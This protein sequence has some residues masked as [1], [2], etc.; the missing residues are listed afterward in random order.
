MSDL[1]KSDIQRQ[2]ILNNKYALQRITEYIGFQGLLFENE[3]RFTK[4]MISEFYEIDER[5]IE[6]YIDKHETE[7]K[8]NGYVLIRGK[9]LKEFKLQFATDIY[10]G[11]KTTVLGLFNFRA[12]LNLG[13]LLTE[14]TK[15]KHL[16]SKILD[17]VID[18]INEK[19]GGGTKFINRQDADYLPAAIRES[20]YR[21]EF[22]SALSRCVDLGNY[23]YV[24]YTDR[25]YQYIFKENAKE[26]KQILNLADKDNAR[27]TMYAEILNLIASFETGLAYEL[28]KKFDNTGRKL[29]P[30]EVEL[31]FREFA[32]HPLQ[33]PHIEDARIKMASR[34]LHFREAVHKKL[35][36]YIQAVSP[37]DFERFLGEQSVDFN[38][39]L[40]E[41][42]DVFKRLKDSE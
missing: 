33:R 41:A 18:T 12:F 36:E 31:I 26:Y 13:M 16:R 11:S 21:K 40:E 19:T 25:I 32:E 23:K 30:N 34:D 20:K 37:S 39:Q 17:I 42:K 35:E 7:I 22:T 3:Y 10:V 28:Q 8:H 4:K 6:R 1:T 38:K 15:A 5:T 2:N 9:R 14:S 27:D 29:T 24:L